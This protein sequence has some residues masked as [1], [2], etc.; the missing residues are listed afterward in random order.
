MQCRFFSSF[1]FD[2][3]ETFNC[4][5]TFVKIHRS[6]LKSFPFRQLEHDNLFW[7]HLKVNLICAGILK[8]KLFNSNGYM[9]KPDHSRRNAN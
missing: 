9:I 8:T 7:S 5:A 3:N 2:D 1:P 4:F 6:K